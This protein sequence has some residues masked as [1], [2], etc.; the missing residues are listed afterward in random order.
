MAG[1]YD[2]SD[3][4]VYINGVESIRTLS[5]GTTFAGDAELMMGADPCF[6]GRIDEVMVFN[7]ALT[8]EEIELHASEGDYMT[9]GY[10]NDY[11]MVST[12]ESNRM[13]TFLKF[14]LSESGLY[15]STNDVFRDDVK[16]ER[17]QLLLYNMNSDLV[18]LDVNPDNLLDVSPPQTVE[19]WGLASDAWSEGLTWTRN[20]HNPEEDTKLENNDVDSDQ[21]WAAWDVT[22]FVENRFENYAGWGEWSQTRW[23]T[24]DALESGKLGSGYDKYDNTDNDEFIGTGGSLTGKGTVTSMIFD[25]GENNAYWNYVDFNYENDVTVEVRFDN[26]PPVRDPAW[27]D[28]MASPTDWAELSAGDI[29]DNYAR[30]IQY[31]VLLDPDNDDNSTFYNITLKYTTF[32]S[33]VLREPY[34]NGENLST[35]INNRAKF[36]SSENS[37]ASTNNVAPMLRIV[38]TRSGRTGNVYTQDVIL[39]FQ[40]TV[41]FGYIKYKAHNEYLQDTNYVYEGGM[42]FTERGDG[43]YQTI[44]DYPP[45]FIEVTGGDGNDAY[46]NV[47]RYQIRESR[48]GGESVGGVGDTVLRAE[49]AGED[50]L[51]QPP[52]SPNAWGA[53][54]TIMTDNPSVWREY[55][56]KI[57]PEINLTLSKNDGE[58]PDYNLYGDYVDYDYSRVGL[59]II[60][61]P[62]GKDPG[63]DVY[64]SEKIV[65]IDVTIGYFKGGKT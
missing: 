52:V 13:W 27:D 31:R 36:I 44:L 55:L 49:Y 21:E 9:N 16:V 4:I 63:K 23:N 54:I 61:D 28:D 24:Q 20:P 53:T 51:V 8:P 41:D 64:Y 50:W 62:T 48:V 6:N 22:T 17:A 33:F 1:V 34:V 47:T 35:T 10:D 14:D 5:T 46:V 19:A 18:E 60:P 43:W 40:G 12:T 65:W 15:D 38:Y 32:V 25:A 3:M 29:P 57:I 30:F 56:E 39:T 11:L 26:D 58:T 2:G 7:R 45:T 37:A 59:T 42:L